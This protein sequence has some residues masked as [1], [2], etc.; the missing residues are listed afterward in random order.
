M[1]DKKEK[2]LKKSLI[3]LS[4]GLMISLM[5]VGVSW[6]SKNTSLFPFYELI[7]L[8]LLDQ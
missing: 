4:L 5:I 7:E 3:Q 8:K 1:A 6:I 2:D